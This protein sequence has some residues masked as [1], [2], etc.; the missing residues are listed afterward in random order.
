MLGYQRLDVYQ[1]AVRLL[2]RAAQLSER[3]PKGYGVLAEQLRRAALSVP[4][5][6]AEGCGRTAAA[7]KARFWS[8]ARGSVMECGA[9]LDAL[10][11]VGCRQTEMRDEASDLVTRLVEMLT[12]MCATHDPTWSP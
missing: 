12:K 9:L 7:D 10:G 1:C 6:V 8:I 5:N 11:A 4:L 2:V 3:V